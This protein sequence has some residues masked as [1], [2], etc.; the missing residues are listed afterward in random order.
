MTSRPYIL[1]DRDGT[2]IVEKNYL[3]SVDQLE[4]LPGAIDGH[5]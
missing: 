5:S 4:F 1:L 2:V 3:S